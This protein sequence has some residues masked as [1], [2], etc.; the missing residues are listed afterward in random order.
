MTEIRIA[1]KLRQ[2]RFAKYDSGEA[3]AFFGTNPALRS[4]VKID[5]GVIEAEQI[6][7]PTPTV[8]DWSEQSDGIQYDDFGNPTTYRKLKVHPG[9]MTW[10]AFPTAYD[11]IPAEFV[12]HYFRADRPGQLRGIP[13]IVPAIGDFADL[14]RFTLATI[15][16]A[17]TAAEH[18]AMIETDAPVDPEISG[19]Q[20]GEGPKTWDLV[21]IQKRAAVVLPSGYKMS[22]FK[23]EHPTTTY[24]EF[25]NAKLN[26]IARCLCVP[27]HIAAMDPSIANMSSSY[28]VGQMYTKERLIDRSDLENLL[29]MAMRMALNELRLGGLIPVMPA[30]WTHQWNW[31]SLS[32]HADPGKEAAAAAERLGSGTTTY[33]L[34][35]AKQGLDAAEQLDAQ[36]KLLGISPDEY[37]HRLLDKLFGT[38]VKPQAQPQQENPNDQQDQQ[39]NANARDSG[40]NGNGRRITG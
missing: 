3:F 38:A 23:P 14:R 5:L 8:S 34:E 40:A 32:H 19:E 1:E 2:M 13:E 22:Q 24:K 35:F 18:A 11:D 9:S 7:N 31:P 16:A 17:E 21:E 30:G 27:F 37:R 15:A 29:N 6:S 39:D 26:E 12:F 20:E 25:V 28:V 33:A 10:N 36:A 4:P